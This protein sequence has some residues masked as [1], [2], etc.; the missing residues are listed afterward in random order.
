M[1]GSLQVLDCSER[2]SELK[3]NETQV[4]IKATAASKVGFDGGFES[5]LAASSKR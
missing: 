3:K 2:C 5:S 1:A 4:S